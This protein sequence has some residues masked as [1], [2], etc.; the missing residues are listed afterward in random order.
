MFMLDDVVGSKDVGGILGCDPETVRRYASKGFFHSLKNRKTKIFSR[1]EILDFKER[2]QAYDDLG[3]KVTEFFV[4]VKEGITDSEM[5]RNYPSMAPDKIR[6]AVKHYDERRRWNLSEFCDLDYED[7]LLL[8]EVAAR[9]KVKWKPILYELT[10]DE[11]FMVYQR[12]RTQCYSL[13][14]LKIFLGKRA[15]KPLYTSREARDIINKINY[16]EIS[17]KI[18]DTIAK[19]EEI[20]RKLRDY[21]RNS[22]YLFTLTEIDF[23][24]TEFNNSNYNN[25][26]K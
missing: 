19:N 25:K 11:N 24:R 23:I 6:S 2:K 18:I 10:K 13:G 7:V 4:L 8:R 9:L 21:V 14:S 16:K 12:K 20:G 26:F 3:N 5:I 1:K 17:I 15:G 22:T